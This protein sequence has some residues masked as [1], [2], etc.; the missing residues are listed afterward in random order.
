MSSLMKNLGSTYQNELYLKAFK[1]MANS[2]RYSI[3]LWL[4]DPKKNFFSELV[5]IEKEGVTMGMIIKKTGLSQSVISQY[6]H[7]LEEAG[8]V[9]CQRKAQFRMCKL[10]KAYLRQIF[11]SLI[12]LL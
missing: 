7:Q 6:I 9:S 12:D 2:D 8:I 10:N 11:E 5:D 1:A 3:V 4:M